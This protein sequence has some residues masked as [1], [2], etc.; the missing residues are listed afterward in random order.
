MESLTSEAT[1]AIETG[2]GIELSRT[3]LTI[4]EGTSDT[5]TVALTTEP[6]ADVTIDVADAG[7]A[8]V[9]PSSLTFTTTDW[10]DPQTVTVSA[11]EDVD[12]TDNLPVTITHAVGTGSA[13][14]YDG[15][16]LPGVEVTVTD[17]DVA[18][19][20][21]SRMTISVEEGDSVDYTV[22]L[23]I[24]PTADVRVDIS[25]HAGTDLTV[26]PTAL[27]FTTGNWSTAQTVTVTAAHD[28][29]AVAEA[30]IILT[31][32][33]NGT[34]DYASIQEQEVEVTITEDDEARVNVSSTE[35][36]AREEGTDGSYD[37]SLSAEPS[38]D[39]TVTITGHANTDASLSS[40]TLTFTPANWRT[41][42]TVTVSAAHDDDAVDDTVTLE[43][44]VAG[45]GEY[46]GTDPTEAEGVI[47]PGITGYPVPDVVV[48]IED[49]DSAEVNVSTENLSAAEGEEATYT[50][51]LTSEPVGS[52]TISAHVDGATTGLR[53]VT[54]TTTDW[55]NPKTVAFTPAEDADIN[56]G[57]HTISHRIGA[58]SA[59]EY[60]NASVADVNITVTDND[61]EVSIAAGSN[62]SEGDN[63]T[64]TLTRTGNTAPASAAAVAVSASEGADF[65][66]ILIRAGQFSA[67]ATT[68][69]FSVTSKEDKVIGAGGG[70]ITATINT[71]LD[72]EEGAGY[73]IK[74]GAGSA[75]VTVTDD[76][77]AADAAW[78]L[79]LSGKT[80]NEAGNGETVT[81]SITNG[82]T[83]AQD[84]D[85]KLFWGGSELSEQRLRLG[86]T[87]THS[88]LTL[89]AGDSSVQ[90]TLIY[91][92]N[93]VRD[94]FFGSDYGSS[95]RKLEARLGTAKVAEVTGV[96]AVDNE[97]VPGV[98][99]SVPPTIQEGFSLVVVVEVSPKA[100]YPITVAISHQDPDGALT[101]TVPTSVTISAQ[102]SSNNFRVNT[103]QDT[104]ELAD[105]TA[106]FTLTGVT[107][108]G[109]NNPDAAVLGS[110][111]S[112]SVTVLNDDFKP[113]APGNLQAD[114]GDT[115]VDLT[116]N[117]GT[118][119]SLNG[120]ST[121]ITGYEY[122]QSTNS[123]KTWNPDWTA[124]SGSG[125][126]T[127]SHQVTGLRNDT[128]YTFQVRAVNAV[129]KGAAAEDT[130]GSFSTLITKDRFVP[131]RLKIFIVHPD[132]YL[133]WRAPRWTPQAG[134]NDRGDNKY[135]QNN[136]FDRYDVQYRWR[137]SNGT[138]SNW[139]DI[140]L[141]NN[142]PTYSSPSGDQPN[143]LEI[144]DQAWVRLGI[145]PPQES[146]PRSPVAGPRPL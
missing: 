29:D 50:L 110:R 47:I 115:V 125:A 35:V 25:G 61:S 20:T 41:A 70:K 119:G 4:L 17:N 117:T 89:D 134:D 22:V 39:V 19:V 48:T 62:V 76:D 63:A 106:T 34:G 130:D 51:V 138:W 136:G 65:L 96:K 142:P 26:S 93:Q 100:S 108:A 42:Q 43:H 116:W 143:S 67:N 49:N 7:D 8:T 6:T 85:L 139:R 80:I 32:E 121:P 90:G 112:D 140:V 72:P 54:F 87:Q 77:A 131:R 45:A 37:V 144:L 2:L 5:Y 73:V 57:S 38:A 69:T 137:R 46:A 27:D 84:Q 33:V 95:T 60:L 15:L 79:S 11:G 127:V 128:E 104:Q 129:G 68:A 1:D 3:A 94:R 88:T 98:N 40:A 124:I 107:V 28:D 21:I 56:D 81:L 36:T 114:S 109:T 102:N 141:F 31:H 18:G 82:Y 103:K 132:W 52:V 10:S 66:G 86:S 99:T 12:T 126:S 23:N 30:G 123:G 105:K 14:E 75:S 53:T 55:D 133:Y 13:P 91:P 9:S 74:S 122:R 59:A 135:Q 83:F 64:F 120:A 71:G 111:T 101:G 58:S 146:L 16:S 118:A 97:S 92:Q 78:S 44:A 113:G 24:L 145:T